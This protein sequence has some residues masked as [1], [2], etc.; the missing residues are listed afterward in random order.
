METGEK[1]TELETAGE[2]P[3]E[4]SRK[5]EELKKSSL[6]KMR[7]IR[8]LVKFIRNNLIYSNSNEAWKRYVANP[9]EFFKNIWSFN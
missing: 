2:I 4:L 8:E 6:P 9:D 3:E 7:Q 5:I 1:L